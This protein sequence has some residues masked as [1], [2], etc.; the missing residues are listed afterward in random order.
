MSGVQLA[1]HHSPTP[2]QEESVPFTWQY[3]IKVE[4]EHA[5]RYADDLA[6]IVC[7]QGHRLRV[8]SK[9]HSIAADGTLHPSYVCSATGCTWHVFAQLVGWGKEPRP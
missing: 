5:A 1:Y 3:P 4:G 9:V 7:P 6:Y 2:W 8:S